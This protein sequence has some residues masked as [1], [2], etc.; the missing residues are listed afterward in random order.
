MC[1]IPCVRVSQ[2][3]PGFFELLD[4]AGPVLVPPSPEPALHLSL[5]AVRLLTEPL[6]SALRGR[7]G[8]VFREKKGP[9]FLKN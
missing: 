8:S 7:G 9:F 2:P 4:H 5:G 1:I 3:V 6:H